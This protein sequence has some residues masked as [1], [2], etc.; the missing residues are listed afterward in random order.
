M[1]YAK[2][3]ERLN[4]VAKKLYVE[5]QHVVPPTNTKFK[6]LMLPTQ[7]DITYTTLTSTEHHVSSGFVGLAKRWKFI[8]AAEKKNGI[9][10]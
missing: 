2:P 10:L 7:A 4:V 1:L 8:S 6:P 3:N 9:I 5:L